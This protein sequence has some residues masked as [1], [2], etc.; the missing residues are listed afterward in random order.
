MK[1]QLVFNRQTFTLSAFP[2][3]LISAKATIVKAFGEALPTTNLNLKVSFTNR[4]N[5]LQMITVTNDSQYKHL[6][7]Q[8]PNTTP[9]ITIEVI[10]VFTPKEKRDIV[11]IEDE[12]T[13]AVT[14]IDCRRKSISHNTTQ[15]QSPINMSASTPNLKTQSKVGVN[16][17]TKGSP[18]NTN[19]KKMS[20]NQIQEEEP[21][22]MCNNC[23]CKIGRVRYTSTAI[24]DYDLCI[25]CFAKIH[26]PYPMIEYVDGKA[27]R[28]IEP[29]RPQTCR[30]PYTA[31]PYGYHEP[32]S[33]YGPFGYPMFSTPTH[34]SSRPI[35]TGFSDFFPFGF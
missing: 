4:S 14:Y 20:T 11:T 34:Y 25:N 27:T 15:K 23:R 9:S 29:P 19:L 35:R 8:I 21:E 12:N 6:L 31:N 24:A 7:S 13:G 1:I 32:R 22:F 18:K 10:P 2:S 26:H 3:T 30:K 5:K 16:Q 17:V 28:R 33:G